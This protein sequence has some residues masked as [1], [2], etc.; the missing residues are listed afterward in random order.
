M[1]NLTIMTSACTLLLTSGAV[2]AQE[3]T[4]PI[5]DHHDYM[6][7]CLEMYAPAESKTE[8]AVSLALCQCSYEK[9]PTSGRMTEAQWTNANRD[10]QAEAKA[11]PVDFTAKHASKAMSLIEKKP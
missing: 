1:R 3:K 7:I 10:C 6:N 11:A 2:L 4:K 9:L 8:R 5:P